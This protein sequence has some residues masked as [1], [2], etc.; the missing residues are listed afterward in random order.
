MSELF[1]KVN[2]PC[3]SILHLQ[4]RSCP[5]GLSEGYIIWDDEDNDNINGI[6]GTLPDGIYNDDTDI[7][8]CCRTDGNKSEPMP[9][10]VRKPFYLLAYGSSECQRVKGALVSEE[11]IQYDTEDTDNADEWGG[12]HPFIS[13]DTGFPTITY[14]Y[15]ESK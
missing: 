4:E 11:F 3:R 12:S 1:K 2:T 15:Y 8:F 7:S 5:N 14:C 13:T 6:G 10:P 9:L